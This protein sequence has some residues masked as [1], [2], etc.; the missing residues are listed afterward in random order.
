MSAVDPN[1]SKWIPWAFV[2]AMGLVV[3]VNGGMIYAALSTFTGVTV[4]QSYDRGRTYNNVIAS[5]ERQAALGWSA[6]V[7]LREGALDVAVR[8]R[9]GL[10]VPGRLE[11]VLQRPLE[12]MALPLDFAALAPGR[13][14]AAV[15][16]GQPGQWEARLTLTGPDGQSFDIRQRVMAP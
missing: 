12:R 8:D 7:T 15:A 1:R 6:Q 5:A 9:E 16:P 13:F 11:G 10:P 4:G 2:G 14:L 3:V